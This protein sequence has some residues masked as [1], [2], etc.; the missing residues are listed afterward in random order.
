MASLQILE[1]LEKYRV[2]PKQWPKRDFYKEAEEIH[3]ELEF[4]AEGEWSERYVGVE[5]PNEPEYCKEHRK[6]V[7]ESPTKNYFEKATSTIGKMRIA[8]DWA[9]TFKEDRATDKAFKEY[10]TQSFPFDDSVENWFFTIGLF[11]KLRD[12]NSV[13]VVEPI[14]KPISDNELPKPYPWIYETEKVLW[15]H[16]NEMY[17]LLEEEIQLE[18]GEGYVFKFVTR[19]EIVVFTQFGKR[20]DWMFKE[21]ETRSYVHNFGYCPA[22]KMG[23]PPKET[24]R[25]ERLYK[26]YLS[27]CLGSWNEACRRSSDLQVNFILHMNPERWEV[28]D[29]E[30]PTCRGNGVESKSIG[31][32]RRNVVC[33]VCNGS[34][35]KSARG[36]YNT[37]FIKLSKQVSQSEHV[38][39]ITPPFGY[40]ERDTKVIELQDEQIG[41][42]IFEG[43]SAINMEYIMNVP[44]STSGVSKAYDKQESNAFVTR[45]LNDVVDNNLHPIYEFTARW[46]FN[47]TISEKD[48]NE[49]VSIN[50]AKKLDYITSDLMAARAEQANK[51][52]FSQ[53]I[54][55]PMQLNYA[56]IELG[57]DTNEY[58]RIKT[59]YDLDP[60]ATKSTDEKMVMQ[61]SA[62]VP[63]EMLILSDNIN[64]LVVRGENEVEN[65][66]DLNYTEKLAILMKYVK[67]IAGTT[68]VIPVEPT[69]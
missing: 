19:T 55:I 13:C 66:Y 64:W 45:V 40:L 60:F 5:R 48:L 53:S 61:A 46:M 34:G 23:G 44:L 41:K 3:E 14:S 39:A 24:N 42:K 54:T 7:W 35:T 21:D 52:G 58:K 17:I 38:P 6:A 28:Q 2:E 15:A 18:D 62:T 65:F 25:L 29:T 12:P 22:F 47:N 27:P 36:P 68:K 67:E 33:H 69:V 4:H 8:E 50:K 56:K 57:E 32:S 9:I 63:R 26:S 59:V 51:S 30:C 11:W 31:N 1:E 10:C 49:L 43:L 16:D 37:K 20:T